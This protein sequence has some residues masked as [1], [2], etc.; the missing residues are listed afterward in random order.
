MKWLLDDVVAASDAWITHKDQL[1]RG[2]ELVFAICE[3]KGFD[4]VILTPGKDSPSEEGFRP[5]ARRRGNSD[6][7]SRVP[8]IIASMAIIHGRAPSTEFDYRISTV[9]D[10]DLA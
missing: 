9:T 3:A 10:S 4:V 8:W 2:T 6:Q 5:S 1:L 7:Y